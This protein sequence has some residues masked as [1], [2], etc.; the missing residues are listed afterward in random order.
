MPEAPGL[1]STMKVWPSRCESFSATMRATGSTPP[2]AE[3]GTTIVT[4]RS[5]HLSAVAVPACRSSAARAE[6]TME[7]NVFTD[8]SYIHSNESYGSSYHAPRRDIFALAMA[9][10]A[11]GVPA[12]SGDRPLYQQVKERL[13]ARISRGEWPPGEAL[14][15][16]PALGTAF[17]VS[18]STIRA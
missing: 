5:G 7:W 10:K 2:P 9:T 12:W 13:I 6:S 11:H 18:I 16:E 3:Y 1:L 8:V 4:G 14:P 17:G 15:G